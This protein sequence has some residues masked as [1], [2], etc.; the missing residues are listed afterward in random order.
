MTINPRKFVRNIKSFFANNTRQQNILMFIVVFAILGTLATLV[1][2]A[3]TYS[4]KVEPENGT[5]TS[6]ATVIDD[7][8]ASGSKAVQ[9][10]SGI[11]GSGGP[12]TLNGSR[13]GIATGYPYN[14]DKDRPDLFSMSYTA[15]VNKVAD[16]GVEWVRTDAIINGTQPL[17]VLDET[18][19]AAKAKN[20]K[21]LI[22]FTYGDITQPD[23]LVLR[24]AQYVD[25][26]KSLNLTSAIGGYEMWN[27]PNNGGDV[28]FGLQDPQAYTNWLKKSYPIL[29]QRTPDVPI[30]SGGLSPGGGNAACCNGNL[31][32]PAD[33]LNK[34]YTLNNNS[35][36]GIFD[37]VGIHP[38]ANSKY[39]YPEGNQSWSG[40]HATHYL[41]Q[42][43]NKYADQAKQIWS[44][45]A[46]WL[47]CGTGEY[48]EDQR[49]V[50]MAND[51]NDWFYG[52]HDASGKRIGYSKTGDW[53]TGPFMIFKL[54]KAGT[55]GTDDNHGLIY[56]SIVNCDGKGNGY[57]P[58]IINGIKFY[59]A[60]SKTTV[61]TAP[62]N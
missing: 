10:K 54:Y 44:T 52:V 15:Y 16:L 27:E 18:L 59:S 34:I 48:T 19:T 13:L 4:V 47:S 26:W 30:I 21:L 12:D 3:A 53:N 9:F 28:R 22:D 41:R 38:Y 23:V 14:K 11:I 61:P 46:G 56:T 51:L 49:L 62:L 17:S 1:S 7:T 35:S 33:Y 31:G 42:V 50:R 36:T 55:G 39:D 57:E 8:R 2:R 29:K 32:N 25:R 24:M 45:E 60:T 6:P 37:A 20:M 43:M 40:L 5:L 58:P